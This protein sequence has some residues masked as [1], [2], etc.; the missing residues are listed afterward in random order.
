MNDALFLKFMFRNTGPSHHICDQFF[1]VHNR[2]NKICMCNVISDIRV[3]GEICPDTVGDQNNPFI[4]GLQFENSFMYFFAGSPGCL[5]PVRKADDIACRK[6]PSVMFCLFCSAALAVNI[7]NRVHHV[8][9]PFCPL[10]MN[11]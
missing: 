9:F 5:I 1:H 11:I 3:H 10:L 6:Q 2:R 4:T 7:Y 8:P